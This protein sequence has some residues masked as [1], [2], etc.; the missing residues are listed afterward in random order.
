MITFIPIIL[1]HM[2]NMM[3]VFDGKTHLDYLDQKSLR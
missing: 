3:F 2:E 1:Y